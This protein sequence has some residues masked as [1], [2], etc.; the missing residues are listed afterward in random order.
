MERIKRLAKLEADLLFKEFRYRTK[1]LPEL[2]ILISE[3]IIKLKEAIFKS[4]ILELYAEPEVH[5]KRGSFFI[6]SPVD[7]EYNPRIHDLC[8]NLINAY[9]PPVLKS[10]APSIISL[11][12]QYRKRLL[13]TALSCKIIYKEGVHFL[14][15][16]IGSN[17]DTLDDGML[18][19]VAFKYISEYE[20][21]T[22]LIHEIEKSRDIQKHILDQVVRVLDIG[23]A[24]AGI[25]DE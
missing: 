2:C 1:S 16:I 3:S 12:L 19:S 13:S 7:T 10:L 18:A 9:I 4:P 15:N 24:R 20:K 25:N 8:I 17:L 23:G 14:E 22:C 5:S 21:I 6:N 11:P